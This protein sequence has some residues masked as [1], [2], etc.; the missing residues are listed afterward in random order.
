M[1]VLDKAGDLNQ[2]TLDAIDKAEDEIARDQ[3]VD[4]DDVRD[5]IRAEFS[6]RRRK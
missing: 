6:G 2:S 5:E 3:F 4:W 1:D